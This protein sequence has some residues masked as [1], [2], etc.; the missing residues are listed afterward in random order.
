MK[1]PISYLK[2]ASKSTLNT[3]KQLVDEKYLLSNAITAFYYYTY[4]K[5][6]MFKTAWLLRG[7]NIH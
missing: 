4:R 6:K 7:Y 1:K 3:P 5:I 2:S